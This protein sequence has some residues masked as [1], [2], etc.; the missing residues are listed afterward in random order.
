MTFQGTI[1]AALKD[2]VGVAPM[3][4][5]VHL[6]GLIVSLAAILVTGAPKIQEFRNA[7]FYSYLGG[8]LNVA[9][10]GG[11]AWAIAKTGATIGANATIVAGV[12]IGSYAFIGAGAVVRHDVP[13]Y[14]LVYGNPAK[15]QGWVCQCGQRLD[16]IVGIAECDHCHRRYR[17]AGEK[18]I[19]LEVQ[20]DIYR[21]KREIK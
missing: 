18:K 4:V 16:F 8:A 20:P 7:P 3:S 5:T 2:R 11:V 21:K 9:I 17:E 14:G 10:I 1:N 19:S 15:L 12:T 13:D 6:I